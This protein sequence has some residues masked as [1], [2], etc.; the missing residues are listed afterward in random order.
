MKIT[1]AEMI[2]DFDIYPRMRVDGSHV[3]RLAAA[4]EAGET[5][6]NIVIDAAT[7]RIVDG[8]H[9]RRAMLRLY[10]PSRAVEVDARSYKSPKEMYLDA[11]RLNSR[12]GKGI[13]GVEQTAAILRGQAMRISVTELADS[14]A[15]KPERV[16][17]IVANKTGTIRGT[18]ERVPLKRCVAHLKKLTRQQ[19]Q[20]MPSLPGQPQILLLKQL[21]LLIETAALR[22]DDEAVREELRRLKHNLNELEL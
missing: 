15:L 12:H 3:A 19:A 9:R 4:L 20:A 10:D 6:P 1:L 5:L 21:N 17:V 13:T 8:F 22:L 7:K 14:M 2:E 16:Q 11:L 18:E